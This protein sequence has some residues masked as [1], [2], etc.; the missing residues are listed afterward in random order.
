MTAR[1]LVAAALLAT[2]PRCAR[3]AQAQGDAAGLSLPAGFAR[4][5]SYAH[6]WSQRGARGY[7]TESDRAE[8]ARVRAMGAT[9]V[10]VMPFG[11]LSGP[12]SAAL[13]TSYDRPGAERDEAL[14][15]TIRSAHAR[16]LR[17]LLKPHL[18]V[19][20]SWPG[21]V[22]P[23]REEDA[24]ALVDAWGALTLHYA[25][26]A[27]QERVEA[28]TVGVEMDR[29]ARRAPARWRAMIAAVRGRFRGTVTY[30]AGWSEVERVPFWDAVDVIG[31]DHYAPL[32]TAPGRVDPARLE[33]AA[34]AS[35]QRYAAVSARVG[36]PVWLTELGFRRDARALLEP[37]LWVAQS[38]A[39]EM[40][41]QSLGYA[42]TLRA[43]RR[44]PCVQGVFAWKWFSSG[45][46]ED[47]GA[48]GFA[49]EHQPA[50]AV[51]REA[52]LA[53]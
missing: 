16:G 36:R 35:L 20:G 42:A 1:A 10:S 31:V 32:A 27:S 45:G 43:V 49:F 22:D 34:L 19:H 37:W 7:G 5:V 26:L 14:R 23:P 12:T 17:V 15:A 18:W 44:V 3:P 39:P 46:A 9:W 13:R 6:D 38:N 30:A 41:L 33:A 25:D 28:L 51:L 8:L 53:R 21:A 29:L 48:R 4:G 24:A 52:F 40:D 50:E 11:Y 2:C 47:E